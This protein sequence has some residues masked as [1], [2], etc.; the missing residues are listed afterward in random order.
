MSLTFSDIVDGIRE[1]PMEGKAELRE[2]LDHEL[3]AMRRTEINASHAETMAEW[4][5][6]ELKPTTN[7]D[8]IMRRLNAA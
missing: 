8:E 2:L 7:V 4:E 1:L 3:I 5:R 6:G